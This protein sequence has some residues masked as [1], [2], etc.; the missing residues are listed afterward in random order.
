[1]TTINQQ[2]PFISLESEVGRSFDIR[3][4]MRHVD[5]THDEGVHRHD[6]QELLW[7]RSGTGRHRIDDAIL[8]I[9]PHTFYLI[10]KGQVH[11]FIEGVDLDGYVLRFS[12]EFLS[13]DITTSEWDYRMTLFSHFSLRQ[14]LSP[15]QASIER[16]QHIMDEMWSE[17]QQ[18][19]FGKQHI[20]R[21][22]L[23]ILIILLERARQYQPQPLGVKAQYMETFQEFITLLEAQFNQ[24]H[25]VSHYAELLHITPRQLSDIVKRCTGKS[26]KTLILERLMLEAKRH[27]Q[28]SNA[29]IKEIAYALG[30]KDSSYFSK[31]FK[32]MT[33]VS[34]NQYQITL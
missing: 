13:A 8:E 34:P 31:V 6:F 29:S 1:M 18:D 22:H 10:T 15:D 14:S 16:F 24:D 7:I 11:Y 32:Q 26:A 4:I 20:L 21:H 33:G 19:G 28:H 2:I 9:Q 23:S 25:S 30:F 3:P 12:D 5:E 17:I 27:L